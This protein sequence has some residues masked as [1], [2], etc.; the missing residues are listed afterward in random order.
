[1]ARA[2]WSEWR[3]SNFYNYTSEN[4]EVRAVIVKEGMLVTMDFRNDRVRVWVDKN[5]IVK[6][7]P[8]IG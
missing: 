1:M 6:Q 8:R 3:S 4:P 7:A 2:G 5:G